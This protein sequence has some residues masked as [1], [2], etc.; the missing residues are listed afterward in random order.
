MPPAEMEVDS[1]PSA[2]RENASSSDWSAPLAQRVGFV[3]SEPA[4]IATTSV[5]DAHSEPIKRPP[6]APPPWPVPI[7]GNGARLHVVV[8]GDS[9][10]R[11]ANRYLDDPRR[12]REIYDLNR[13]LIAS[14]DLLPIGV[15]LKIPDRSSRGSW[16]RAND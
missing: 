12:S 14:P 13:E 6:V 2:G 15:E 4:P 3:T 1:A 7:D 10:E 5:Y 8:D 11:L 9:L 16:D